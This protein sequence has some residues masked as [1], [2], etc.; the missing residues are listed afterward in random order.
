VGTD[1]RAIHA[2]H[3]P[4]A[5]GWAASRLGSRP[6]VAHD[7]QAGFHRRGMDRIRRPPGRRG[8]RRRRRPAQVLLDL[9]DRLPGG[10]E[11]AAKVE[12]KLL[13][14]AQL[15][16][17]GP[18]QRTARRRRLG[19]LF[20]PHPVPRQRAGSVRGR[21]LART[22]ADSCTSP[23]APARRATV[24]SSCRALPDARC[25]Q[26]TPFSPA[27]G[28]GEQT[29]GPKNADVACWAASPS[30]PADPE[31]VV[32][33]DVLNAVAADRVRDQGPAGGTRHPAPP[34]AWQSRRGCWPGSCWAWS[35][36]SPVAGPAAGATRRPAPP[37]NAPAP[38][39]PRAEPSH[40]T[41]RPPNRRDHPG[42]PR[43][44]LP[45]PEP[46]LRPSA[47]TR[48]RPPPRGRLRP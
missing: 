16:P 4:A 9:V 20:C 42:P 41:R 28:D 38:D 11:G 25:A 27:S 26:P 2:K 43:T 8:R 12:Q 24:G 34:G 1:E 46:R 31:V 5:T 30:C 22:P 45:R 3:G 10:G 48:S 36:G 21:D 40:R 7:V 32:D 19:H 18:G 39:P 23:T 17:V 33:A 15:P 37:P 35:W 29:P 47:P 6:E 44:R 13:Q 14:L